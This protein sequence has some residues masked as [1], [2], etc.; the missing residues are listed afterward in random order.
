M[1]KEEAPVEIN[2]QER[3]EQ[4]ERL[5]DYLT[6]QIEELTWSLE[7]ANERWVKQ[8]NENTALEVQLRKANK[9]G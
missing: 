3:A 6:A 8:V 9:R 5:N 2:W 7:V 4:A 1:K